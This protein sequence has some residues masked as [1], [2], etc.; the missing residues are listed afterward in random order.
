MRLVFLQLFSYLFAVLVNILTG[1]PFGAFGPL[2]LGLWPGISNV[3]G[4]RVVYCGLLL[5]HFWT[6]LL[7]MLKISFHGYRDCGCGVW[8]VNW[9]MYI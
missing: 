8:V 6:Y 4:G 5:V 7:R 9:R 2:A 3:C 1:L